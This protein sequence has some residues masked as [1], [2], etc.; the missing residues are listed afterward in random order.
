MPDQWYTAYPTCGGSN[1]SP[2]NIVT[3]DVVPTSMAPL[4]V[5]Y[6]NQLIDIEFQNNGHTAAVVTG[7]VPFSLS[8]LDLT[9]TFDLD[10]FHF[11][12]NAA[13]DSGS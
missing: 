2:I 9:D 13:G 3:A 5:T 12:W 6:P 10:T 1:Q 8:G 7:Q 4:T 11:H